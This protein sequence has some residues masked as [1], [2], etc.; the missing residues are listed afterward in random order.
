MAATEKT[1]QNCILHL[2]LCALNY[3]IIMQYMAYYANGIISLCLQS[4]KWHNMPFHILQTK[5]ST[6]TRRS[7]YR[8][9]PQNI[10][11]ALHRRP[12]LVQRVTKELLSDC[13][14]WD[15]KFV[16]KLILYDLWFSR[17]CNFT[18]LL[19]QVTSFLI[20]TW[21]LLIGF[22]KGSEVDKS[23]AQRPMKGK[24]LT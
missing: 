12:R 22:R 9:Y 15:E 11:R 4:M 23:T 16:I 10:L 6:P 14:L 7:R 19:P 20:L 5:T 3:R 18:F 17:Y 21:D 2:D 1:V 24:I 13:P 8:C